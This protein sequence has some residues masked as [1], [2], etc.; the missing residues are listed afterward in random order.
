MEEY[1]VK[2]KE[3]MKLGTPEEEAEAAEKL[4]KELTKGMTVK[5]VAHDWKDYDSHMKEVCKKV[6]ELDATNMHYFPDFYSFPHGSLDGIY[7]VISKEEI[8]EEFAE[9]LVDLVV[10]LG[11]EGS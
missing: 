5:L 4:Y 9:I 8:P 2:A 6:K 11:A 1:K 10:N 3:I 7:T